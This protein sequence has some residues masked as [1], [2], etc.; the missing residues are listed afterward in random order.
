MSKKN[1][2]VGLLGVSVLT[3]ALVGCGIFE[4]VRKEPKQATLMIDQITG[5]S[6]EVTTSI[7][8]LVTSGNRINFEQVTVDTISTD[9]DRQYDIRDNLRFYVLATNV[10]EEAISFRMRVWIDDKSWY[11]EEK[12]LTEGETAQFVYRYSSPTLY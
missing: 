9:I 10:L 3:F 1:R 7:D 6:V 4:T 2:L 8:F 5:P 12:T 11:N